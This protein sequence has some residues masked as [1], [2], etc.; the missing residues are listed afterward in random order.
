[1]RAGLYLAALAALTVLTMTWAGGTPK[2]AQ[3]AN[4]D[5]PCIRVDAISGGGIDE[6]ATVGGTFTVDI[7][8]QNTGGNIS[9]FNVLLIYNPFMLRAHTPVPSPLPG[10][11]QC[12]PPDASGDLPEDVPP[13]DGNPL[14]GDAFISCFSAVAESVIGDGVLARITFD[15]IGSGSSALTI[16]SAASGDPVGI[17]F[18]TCEIN[19]PATSIGTCLG[20]S[21]ATSGNTPPPPPPPPSA[22]SCTVQFAIDGETVQCADGSRVRF[23]GV[24]SPLGNEPGADWARAVT[25]WFLA[26]K[27]IT[28]E[29]DAAEFD[30]FGSRW[31]Y[32]HVIGTN[33]NDYNISV[34]LIYVGMARH[35]PEAPNLKHNDWLAASQTWARVACWNMWDGGNPWAGESGCS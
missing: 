18:V 32:P 25:Q 9:A 12:S 19:Q 10:G 4:C 23:I 22:N 20:A 30:Q 1:L 7:V 8:S 31:A 14:T 21:V 33:G 3:A 27:T 24:G 35:V 11:W 29:K 17:P 6:T 5:G 13:A 28:L 16:T 15:V 34:L 2:G 26:G